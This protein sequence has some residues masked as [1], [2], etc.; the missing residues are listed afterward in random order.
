VRER[1]GIGRVCGCGVV[2]EAVRRQLVVDDGSH[3]WRLEGDQ[4]GAG[5]A[6]GVFERVGL[7]EQMQVVGWR[8]F[9]LG[10]VGRGGLVVQGC[11]V[12]EHGDAPHQRRG[13]FGVGHLAGTGQGEFGRDPDEP[14]GGPFVAGCGVHGGDQ[15]GPG[16]VGGDAVR[17][18]AAE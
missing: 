6:G 7:V 10:R 17:A 3:G 16:G 1:A 13:E 15:R 14:V 9:G 11:E 2:V 5:Q 4:F 8:E 12:G 18:G